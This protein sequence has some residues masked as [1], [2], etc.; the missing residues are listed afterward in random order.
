MWKVKQNR[1][2]VLKI[3]KIFLFPKHS[4]P[5]FHVHL[6]YAFFSLSIMLLAK[7]HHFLIFHSLIFSLTPFDWLHSIMLNPHFWWE[8]HF[9][10]K[11]FWFMPTFSGTQLGQKHRMGVY[12]LNFWACFCMWVCVWQ[13]MYLKV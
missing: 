2:Y 10:F 4:Q 9:L 5:L 3:Q 6:F 1:L 11:P 8:Y 7:F 12:E 13:H